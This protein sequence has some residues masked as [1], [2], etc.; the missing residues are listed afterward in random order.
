MYNSGIVLLADCEI[1]I[2][3]LHLAHVDDVIIP[4]NE[5]VYL[6]AVYVIITSQ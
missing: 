6:R 2:I 1:L 3:E 4:V 5:H